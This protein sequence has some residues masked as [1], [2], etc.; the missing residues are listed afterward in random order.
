MIF[1]NVSYASDFKTSLISKKI[2][3]KMVGIF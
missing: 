2:K 1:L 3:I